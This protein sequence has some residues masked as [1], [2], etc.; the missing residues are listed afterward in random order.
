MSF[1]SDN[2]GVMKGKKNSVLSRIK[3]KQPAVF[4]MGCITHLANLCCVAGVKAL[5]L[6]IND[7]LVDIY[8]HFHHSSKR[9][10]EFKEYEEFTGVDHAK[11]L[12]HCETRWLSLERCVNRTLQQ[13][14]ALKSYFL[15][16]DDVE[17]PGRVKRI[18]EHLDSAEMKL[19]F[20]FLTFILEPLNEFN[21]LFQADANLLDVMVREM[22]RHLKKLLT[23]FV[24]MEVLKSADDI[25]N[26]DYLNPDNIQGD[27]RIAV[28]R[29]ARIMLHDKADNI[30]NTTLYRFFSSVRNFYV[31]VVRK[32]VT[33]F[34]FSEEI[35]ADLSALLGPRSSSKGHGHR[36]HC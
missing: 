4:D 3:E 12:K 10:E 24:K 36:C 19:Y 23:K 21:T 29:D 7:F 31:A 2:C 5:P 22:R 9:K 11:I 6:P 8:Y 16:H 1:N 35:L 25:I 14:P 13:W 15:S 34:P 27:D 20:H 17:K 26:V 32:M 30:D 28:G 33:K 18:A